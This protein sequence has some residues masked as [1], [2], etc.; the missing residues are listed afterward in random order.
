MS[1]RGWGATENRRGVGHRLIET[2]ADWARGLRAR[3]MVLWVTETN[4]SART[5]YEKSGFAPTGDRQPLPSDT[6]LMESKLS[7]EIGGLLARG[8]TWRTP[9]VTADDV[10]AR[11]AV[12]GDASA[13]LWKA[14]RRLVD[15]GEARG[16]ARQAES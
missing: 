5:L 11:K 3:H 10:R 8:G 16:W 15:E 12:I 4:R 6:S 13:A 14:G 2:I 9:G 1:R 7:R